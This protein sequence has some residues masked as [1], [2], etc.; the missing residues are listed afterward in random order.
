MIS[1]QLVGSLIVLLAGAVPVAHSG[2]AHVVPPPGDESGW[3]V[4]QFRDGY[5]RYRIEPGEEQADSEQGSVTI[6]PAGDPMP[7]PAVSGDE[8]EPA[9]S[10]PVVVG[11]RRGCI[12]EREDLAVRL[13]AIRG[14]ELDGPTALLH[15]DSL[16][17]PWGDPFLANAMSWDWE[18]R[19]LSGNLARCLGY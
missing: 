9:A 14:I 7:P 13:A 10:V 1:M 4:I 3:R 8:T 6:V 17:V 11:H 2:E 18:T 16:S 12:E 15:Q 19:E 5:A